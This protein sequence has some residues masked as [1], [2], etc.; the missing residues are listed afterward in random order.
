MDE[1]WLVGGRVLFAANFA[2][3][4]I[5]GWSGFDC[6]CLDCEHTLPWRRSGEIFR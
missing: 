2:V 4:E 6:I 3:V 1:D 5:D